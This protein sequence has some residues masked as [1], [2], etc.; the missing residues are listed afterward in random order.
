MI[1][2]SCKKNIGRVNFCPHCGAKQNTTPPKRKKRP[3]GTGSI[4]KKNGKFQAT[5]SSQ[6]GDR[7]YL[8]SFDTEKQATQAINMFGAKSANIASTKITIEQIYFDYVSDNIEKLSEKAQETYKLAWVRLEPL[9]KTSIF[10]LKLKTIQKVFDTYS[11]EHQKID[12][13]GNKIFLTH[14]GK[15]TTLNTGFAKMQ[16][17][18]SKGTLKNMKILLA[19][20]YKVA[21]ANDWAIKDYSQFVNIETDTITQRNMSRFTKAELKSFFDLVN[22]FDY[23]D[24]IIIMS[25]TNFRVSEFLSLTKENYHITDSGVPY[26]QGGVKT[27]AGKNRVVPIHK[28]IQPLVANCIAKNGD[29]I[30]CDKDTLK[31]FNVSN[32]RYRFDKIIRELGFGSEFTPHSCRR[33]FSTLFSATGANEADL[34]AL[35]GHT[36]IE[37]DIHYYIN[38]EVETLY[39]AINKI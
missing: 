21:M 29:T 18:L 20:I 5:T 32:F 34:I 1:C 30:F 31:E 6:K 8:G 15:E 14:E 22:D 35:M 27:Q 28:D 4:Y 7:V 23:L 12:G 17:A 25:Y 2:N 19:K 39:N 26:F 16:K 13:N 3:N 10:S 24:Y 36:K 37:T 9:W 38:Q 11:V 33:T